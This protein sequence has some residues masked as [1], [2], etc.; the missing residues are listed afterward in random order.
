MPRR[1]C[2]S[3]TNT[4]I[5][6]W[7]RRLCPPPKTK[8]IFKRL[9]RTALSWRLSPKSRRKNCPTTQMTWKMLKNS[10][11]GKFGSWRGF[12]RRS[13]NERNNS[14]WKARGRA[15]RKW[16]IK[17]CSWRKKCS[18]PSNSEA[19]TDSC[20]STTSPS[21]IIRTQKSHCSKET[22]MSLWEW[23]PSIRPFFRRECSSGETTWIKKA[24]ESTEIWFRRTRM[25]LTTT[26]GK[27][28]SRGRISRQTKSLIN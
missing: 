16:P 23:T 1:N 28:T 14:S 5:V 26:I 7:K 10:K 8:S 6:Q 22:T 2:I 3:R 13:G 25:S 24:R 21:P 4:S 15:A 12:W 27:G 9:S 18:D 19:T 20:R 11:S 17:K